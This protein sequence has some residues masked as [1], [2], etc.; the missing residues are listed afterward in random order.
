MASGCEVRHE[1]MNRDS[2]QGLSP[3][4]RDALDP[5]LAEIESLNQRI[6]EYDRRIEQIAKQAHPEVARL[7]QVKGVGTLIALTYVLTL[8]DPRPISPQS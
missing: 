5:L 6:A 2:A 1:Q 4:L 7:K 3:E 8:D